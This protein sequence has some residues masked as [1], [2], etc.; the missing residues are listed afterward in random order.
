MTFNNVSGRPL[1]FY[2]ACFA[3]RQQFLS[4]STALLDAR[5]ICDHRSS[6]C[7]SFVLKNTVDDVGISKRGSV[8]RKLALWSYHQA[9]KEFRRYV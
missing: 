2:A 1:T 9:V 5:S 8:L 7:V 3:H 4:K 6:V